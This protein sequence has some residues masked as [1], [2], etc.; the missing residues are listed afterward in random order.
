MDDN[1]EFLQKSL[2]RVLFLLEDNKIDELL[3]FAKTTD[4]KFISVQSGLADS[5]IWIGYLFNYMQELSKNI[6]VL[7][8]RQSGESH[9]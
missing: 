1:K 8:R 7:E 9:T 5:R 6:E 3:L 2:T 4:G